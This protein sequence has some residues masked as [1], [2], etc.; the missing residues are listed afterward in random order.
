[1]SLPNMRLFLFG[2]AGLGIFRVLNITLCVANTIQPESS[3]ES[4]QDLSME[5][6][7]QEQ[8]PVPK[9][10]LQLE[11]LLSQRNPQSKEDPPKAAIMPRTGRIEK[12]KVAPDPLH[13][14]P[15]VAKLINKVMIAGKKGLAQKIVY[16]AFEKIREQGQDP[17]KTFEQALDNISPKMEVRPRRVGGASYMV[18]LEVRGTRRQSLAVS[19]LVAAARSRQPAQIP[20]ADRPK[21]KPLMVTKLALEIIEAAAGSGKAHAK[22]EEMHRIAEANKAFAHFRW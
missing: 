21:N 4:S 17:L 14:S 3:A 6:R 7:S 2:V 11:P 20:S 10:P 18:P 9:P 16:G 8:S 12:R 13:Q 22:K 15:L 19:W 1:M 5:P